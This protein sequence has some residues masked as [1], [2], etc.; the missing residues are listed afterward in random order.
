MNSFNNRPVNAGIRL[1]TMLLNHIFMTIIILM[2]FL[3]TMI[4]GFSNA[5]KVTH[6]KTNF[7]FMQGPMEYI[8]MFGFALYFCKDVINGLVFQNA[9]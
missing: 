6:E 2:F 7:N 1:A 4:A 3:P 9:F 8:T 5:F